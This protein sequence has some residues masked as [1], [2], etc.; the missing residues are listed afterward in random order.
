MFVHENIQFDYLK[1]KKYKLKIKAP[2]IEHL[3][4]SE[5][6][7]GGDKHIDI[8]TFIDVG[9]FWKTKQV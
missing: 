8:K 4:G 1:Q 6:K 2:L 5:A 9:I 3:L 7:A